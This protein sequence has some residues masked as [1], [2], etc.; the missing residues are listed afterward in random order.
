[1]EQRAGLLHALEI[2]VKGQD[3]F[4]IF[5]DRVQKA[6]ERR[7]VRH[8]DDP[9]M[10]ELLEH[11][12]SVLTH[13]GAY[14]LY[15]T[16]WCGP[17]LYSVLGVKPGCDAAEIKKAYRKM[18]VRA[19][20]DKRPYSCSRLKHQAHLDSQRVGKAYEVLCDHRASYDARK[21]FDY[22]PLGGND[23]EEDDDGGCH[24]NFDADAWAASGSEAE[25]VPPGYDAEKEEAGRR[26]K[27]T[28]SGGRKGKRP[29]A[30][31][32]KGPGRPPP[33]PQGPQRIELSCTIRDLYRGC[34]R[35]FSFAK[36]Y[37]LPNGEW[38]N[39]TTSMDLFIPD[40]TP[41]G[42]YQTLKGYGQ[43]NHRTGSCDDLEIVLVASGQSVFRCEGSDLVTKVDVNIEQALCGGKFTVCMPDGTDVEY[44]FTDMLCTGDVRHVSD[45]GFRIAGAGFGLLKC[46]IAVVYGDWST[47]QR[48]ALAAFL[49]GIRSKDLEKQARMTE[50]VFEAQSGARTF[51]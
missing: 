8:R 21:S 41:T 22:N 13:D 35:R 48:V 36:G 27:R 14:E 40:R 5:C 10:C 49:K 43:Y 50:I 24:F 2:E 29:R 31:P 44:E 45:K 19:H 18:M 1:M 12:R 20:V 26:R 42:P 3:P 4:G 28:K 25:E 15:E 39:R 30:R 34:R 46:N 37:K 11:A 7:L 51:F 23:D 6:Y 9:D 33:Q 17:N 47:Q 32:K 16:I 38:F